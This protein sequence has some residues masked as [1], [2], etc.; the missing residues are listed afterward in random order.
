MGAEAFAPVRLRL[1]EL[2][3]YVA[4]FLA[5]YEQKS[6]ETRA[7]YNRALR[8]FLYFFTR[9]RRFFFR[10]RDVERYR[11]YLVRI[12][13]LQPASVATY[14]TALRRLCQYLVD[15]G[16]LE[17]N[18][19]RRVLGARRAQQHSRLFLT[20]AEIEQLLASIETSTLVGLRDRAL[21]LMMLGCACS[22]REL[23][24]AD[25]GDIRRKAGKW[26]I[27]LQGKGH[28]A[29]DEVV[30]IPPKVYEALTA[31]LAARGVE[32]PA[33]PL[34][35]SYSPRGRGQRM[36]VRGMREVVNQRLRESG[37]K[38]ERARKLTPFSLRHTAGL[39]LVES[40]VSVE[41]LMQRMRIRW[42]PT[43]LLYV[44]QRGKVGSG[45]ELQSL[46]RL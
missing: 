12:K 15:R 45:P 22:E 46:V 29:K 25:V 24:A 31:Y 39:L 3:E 20:A 42:R 33:E 9:D 44:R 30:P 36:S 34:F 32:D 4:G 13:K 11:A 14:M 40:G 28:R 41:E 10:P 5:A 2:M 38:R 27:Y 8:E 35:V 17:R 26:V 43:A 21:I 6:W 7:T 16:V 1:Q 19:A 18:P 37:I 23:A